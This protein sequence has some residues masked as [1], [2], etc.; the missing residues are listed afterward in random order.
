VA[1]VKRSSTLSCT[2]AWDGASLNLGEGVDH[3]VHDPD[4][5]VHDG[6]SRCFTIA[7]LCLTIHRLD[8]SRSTELAL[9]SELLLSRLNR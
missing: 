1:S 2:R 7:D 4:L 9:L 5:S 3:P 8:R 6:R